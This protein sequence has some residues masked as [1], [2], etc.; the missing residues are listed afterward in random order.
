[1]R[2]ADNVE[3]T[4]VFPVLPSM[5][6]VEFDSGAEYRVIDI[7]PYLSMPVFSPLNEPDFF[8]QA[9]VDPEVGTV[10]WPGDIDIA[11]ETLYL[12]SVP[13][14]DFTQRVGGVNRKEA[15]GKNTREKTWLMQFGYKPSN[16][17]GVVDE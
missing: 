5:L 6:I 10:I 13:L 3:I 2:T 7:S 14:G 16:T 15:A 9:K 17:G 11:P 12:D 1:M 8:R 4:N